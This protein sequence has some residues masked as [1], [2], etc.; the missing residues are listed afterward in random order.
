[1]EDLRAVFKSYHLEG[2]IDLVCIFP[3][4]RKR[5]SDGIRR[6]EKSAFYRDTFPIVSKV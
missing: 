2:K 5:P 1:M 6:R 4:R 3:K